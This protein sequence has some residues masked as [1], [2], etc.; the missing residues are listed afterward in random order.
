MTT[1]QAAAKY[2]QEYL[3]A[4]GNRP[5]AIYNPLSKPPVELPVIYGFNNGRTHSWLHA[6]LVAEDGTGLGG[7]ICSDEAY[8][9]GDLGC[10][11]GTAE[12][13]HETFRVYY[14]QGYRMMFVGAEEA[15]THKGL[16][17]AIAN[18]I[19]KQESAK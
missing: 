19:A 15:K 12:D 2:L 17:Q 6:E 1:E 7:H 9:P 5:Y 10:L 4:I 8:M 3:G 11:E 18:N 14:P 13:R 16:Q